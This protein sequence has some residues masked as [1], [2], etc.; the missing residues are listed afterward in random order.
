[1]DEKKLFKDEGEY[2]GENY[3]KLEGKG[4][5][6][7]DILNLYVDHIR[8]GYNLTVE[9]ICNYLQCSKVHFLSNYRDSI[10]HIRITIIIRDI[11]FTLLK[12][13]EI[14]LLE[15]DMD[16]LISL[17]LKRI[18]YNRDDF[19]RFIAENCFIE[20]KYKRLSL[21]D[22]N[23]KITDFKDRMDAIDLL[24]AIS[25]ELYGRCDE[26]ILKSIHYVPGELHS[27][28]SSLQEFGMKYDVEFYRLIKAKGVNKICLGN[29][30]RYDLEDFEGYYIKVN[31]KEWDKLGTDK[32]IKNILKVYKIANIKKIF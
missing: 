27:L 30:A 22:F 13:R 5:T 10:K 16:K 8:E 28:K 6:I 18:L 2:F 3:I 17:F 12:K 23:L 19:N 21:E 26:G 9:E 7:R 4:I 11:F 31:Y 29:L 14:D 24:N 25:F 1:M 20:H 15:A 32:I